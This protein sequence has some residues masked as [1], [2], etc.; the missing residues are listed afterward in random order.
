MVR[1]DKQYFWTWEKY[2]SGKNGSARPPKK[3]AR[4]PM[5]ITITQHKSMFTSGQSKTFLP[6]STEN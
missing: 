5:T 1:L 6:T 4:K 2:F 3:L